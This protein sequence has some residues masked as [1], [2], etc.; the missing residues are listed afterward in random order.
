MDTNSHLQALRQQGKQKVRLTG[1]I[2]ET[3]EHDGTTVAKIAI[4]SCW[5]E[6]ETWALK[7]THLGEMV[8]LEAGLNADFHALHA[9]N[10]R[11]EDA[12]R[13]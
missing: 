10:H 1:E 2:V 8:I 13:T 12:G 5:L 9:E 3:F 7:S 6:V 11:G 4:R